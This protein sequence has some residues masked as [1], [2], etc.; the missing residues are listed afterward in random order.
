MLKF[1]QKNTTKMSAHVA[2][3]S[4]IVLSLLALVVCL[5][6]VPKLAFMISDINDQLVDDMNEFKS[7]E[8]GIWEEYRSKVCS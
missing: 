8:Q 1:L 6:S 2:A 7:L 3:Y 5:V 4:A